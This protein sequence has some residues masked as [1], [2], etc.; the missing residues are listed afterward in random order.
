MNSSGWGDAWMQAS[1]IDQ[2][3]LWLLLTSCL[4][5]LV[6]VLLARMVLGLLDSV[7]W[8]AMEPQKALWIGARAAVAVT[9][10]IL[11]FH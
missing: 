6:L 9:L 5:G 11:I 3:E 4:I 10:L 7:T 2:V 1:G 8:A